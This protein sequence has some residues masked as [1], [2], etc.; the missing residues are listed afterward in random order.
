MSNSTT[1]KPSSLGESSKR[2]LSSPLDLNDPKKVRALSSTSEASEMEAAD[3]VMHVNFRE[4]DL[5]KISDLLKSS[6]ESQFSSIVTNIVDG[7]LQGLN[8]KIEAL[9][10][11]NKELRGRV[12]DLENRLEKVDE[13]Q[14]KADQYSRRNNVRLSGIAE[15][16]EESTD[17]IV[18]DL[19]K[20]IGSDLVLDEIDRSHRL[21][22]PRMQPSSINAGP[23][24][25]KQGQ[26]KLKPR[27]IIIKFTSY[28]ARSKLMKLKSRL[29]SA[30]YKG[31]FVNEDLTQTRSD[32]FYQARQ[33]VK[34]KLVNDTWTSDGVII[35]KDAQNKKHR[36]E[37]KS[38][39]FTLKRKLE[40][41]G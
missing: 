33:L 26:R 29:G 39:L 25:D 37:T 13:K 6:F 41:A 32:L 3:N 1:P 18:T 16:D 7:V 11:E 38:D 4:E 30:G 36:I 28:R 22:K 40:F 24:G 12:S 9:E 35:I 19:A 15:S 17:L 27:D 8:S 20:A 14:D 21:G 5:C 10:H 31:V 23:E 2:E 34:K